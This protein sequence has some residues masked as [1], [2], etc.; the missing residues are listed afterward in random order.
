[1]ARPSCRS[2]GPKPLRLALCI[3][4]MPEKGA[5]RVDDRAGKVAF[6]CPRDSSYLKYFEFLEFRSPVFRY[7]NEDACS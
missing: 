6:S 5:K 2:W 7:A 1:M 4:L 3:L